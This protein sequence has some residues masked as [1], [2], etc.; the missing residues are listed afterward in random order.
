MLFQYFLDDDFIGGPHQF[1][2]DRG[3]PAR[4]FQRLTRDGCPARR[5]IIRKPTLVKNRSVM[6]TRPS[7]QGG[8]ARFQFIE[9]EW[10]HKVIVGSRVEPTQPVTETTPAL[11]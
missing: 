11:T 5:R 9:V 7:Q 3:S 10:L 2:K 4:E 1:L 8:Q 6:K